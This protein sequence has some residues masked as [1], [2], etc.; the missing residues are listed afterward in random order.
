MGIS[1]LMPK[2]IFLSAPWSYER[3]FNAKLNY[4]GKMTLVLKISCLFQ[5]M[6]F[7]KFQQ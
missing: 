5:K 4:G 2:R 3:Y 1:F 6:T 7:P